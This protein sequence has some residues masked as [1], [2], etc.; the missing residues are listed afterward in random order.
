MLGGSSASKAEWLR[1]GGKR[2]PRGFTARQTDV[3]HSDAAAGVAVLCG[4]HRQARQGD[5]YL[6]FN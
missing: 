3:K 2:A 6:L 4:G 1:C 5:F